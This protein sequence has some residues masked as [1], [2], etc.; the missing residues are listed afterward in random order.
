MINYCVC[1]KVEIDNRWYDRRDLQENALADPE[2]ARKLSFSGKYLHVYPRSCDACRPAK[3][4]S[5][6]SCEQAVLT[7]SVRD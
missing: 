4:Q 5:V 1:G 7:V 6:I 2:L 3:V